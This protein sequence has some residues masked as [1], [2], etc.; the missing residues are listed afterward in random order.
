MYWV[1]NSKCLV[2]RSVSRYIV[3]S[4][5]CTNTLHV[6]LIIEHLVDC[7]TAVFLGLVQTRGLVKRKV[8]S[9]RG[10]LA[11]RAR[12]FAHSQRKTTVL[13]SKHLVIASEECFVCWLVLPFRERNTFL[14]QLSKNKSLY[15]IYRFSTHEIIFF[16]QFQLQVYS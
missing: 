13:Q 10:R 9:G 1:S 15:C 3:H 8:R 16:S 14:M 2:S 11:L 7:K 6:P 4:L 5:Y 12:E